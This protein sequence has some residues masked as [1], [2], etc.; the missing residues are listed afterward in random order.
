MRGGGGRGGWVVVCDTVLYA[1]RS[2]NR[3]NLFLVGFFCVVYFALFTFCYN[4]HVFI[5]FLFLRRFF[6]RDFTLTLPMMRLEMYAY[7]HQHAVW[8]HSM[9]KIRERVKSL[10]HRKD[11]RF[12]FDLFVGPSGQAY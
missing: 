12:P 8:E 4:T 6:F 2:G 11:P 5:C 9:G 10:S 3:N 7:D 1:A